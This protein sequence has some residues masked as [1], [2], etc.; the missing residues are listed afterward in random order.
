MT[1]DYALRST[2]G[3]NYQ[4]TDCTTLGAYYQTRQSY[5]F[6]NAFLIDRPNLEVSNDVKMDLPQNIGF[7]LANHT[8]MDGRL[9]VGVDVLYKLWDEAD[10]FGSVYDNQWVLQLGTQYTVGRAGFVQAILG[11]E[12]NRPDSRIKR[13]GCRPAGRLSGCALH[14][15]LARGHVSASHLRWH[16]DR[17]CATGHRHG[18]DGGRHV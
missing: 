7:G 9:L 3:A 12:S 15:G 13:R 16:R 8:L 17:G 14:S 1:P 6:D 11:R 2:L 5:T 4:L 18:L 10:L